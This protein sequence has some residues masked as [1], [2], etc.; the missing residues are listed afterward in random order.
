MRTGVH[1]EAAGATAET[2]ALRAEFT[3]VAVL[4]VQLGLVLCAVG[5]VEHLAAHSCKH[6]QN[7]QKLTQGSAFEYRRFMLML[8]IC[9]TEVKLINY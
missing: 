4:A 3:R 8:Y 2:V 7:S 5:G 6:H 1:A 9:Q